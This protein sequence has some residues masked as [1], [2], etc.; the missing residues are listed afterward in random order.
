MRPRL[1]AVGIIPARLHSTRLPE[2]PLQDLGGKPL[3]VRVW[4][5]ARAATRLRDLWVATDSDKIAAVVREAGGQALLTNPDHPAGLDRVA[6]AVKL[7]SDAPA[8]DPQTVFV[9]LQGDEPFVEP[10]AIDHLVGLFEN[11]DVRMA[12]LAAPFPDAD[13]QT[14]SRVKVVLDREG[15]ALYFS[16]APIPAGYGGEA[17]ALLHLG[18]YAYRRD[19]L[20]QLARLPVAPLERAERL[21]QLRALWNGIPIHVAVGDW[22][23]F[24]IDTPEDLARARTR[25]RE[26]RG[27]S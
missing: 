16:R 7:L 20:L 27:T 11:P 13:V 15:R 21:E 8:P 1:S 14:P 19:T 12:T 3:V 17:P 4:E 9:N 23:A 24:G 26:G 18:I 2:K 10:G 25:F 6:E 22:T 5:Q